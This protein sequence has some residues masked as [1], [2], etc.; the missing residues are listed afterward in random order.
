MDQHIVE[1]FMTKCSEAGL[2]QSEA[3]YLLKEAE[4]FDWQGLLQD[5][6]T[7]GTLGGAALGG[8]GTHM[9]GGNPWMTGLGALA[10]GAGGYYGTNPLMDW[11]NKQQ[12]FQN[13]TGGGQQ[14][15]PPVTAPGATSDAV[16]RTTPAAPPS[17][18][19]TPPVSGRNIAAPA[20]T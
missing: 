13:F 2:S 9:M 3:M 17:P 16:P 19:E 6:R 14:E 11:L 8:L 20:G 4:G 5:P 1:G 12:W 15:G 10:G 7:W 18:G